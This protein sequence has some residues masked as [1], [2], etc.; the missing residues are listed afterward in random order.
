MIFVFFKPFT[1]GISLR[2]LTLR[3]QIF[4][5]AIVQLSML[6][7]N[8]LSSKSFLSSS[9][10]HLPKHFASIEISSRSKVK[11]LKNNNL[12]SSA[13]SFKNFP[14]SDIWL[15]VRLRA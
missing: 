14:R 6:K 5:R 4:I 13:K 8:G 10:R 15:N 11:S 2:Y 1:S 7:E 9:I 3:A 12:S